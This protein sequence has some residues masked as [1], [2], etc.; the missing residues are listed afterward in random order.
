MSEMFTW[1]G[2]SLLEHWTIWFVTLVLIVAAVIDGMLLK[3]PNWLTFPFV[4]S[5]W[6]YST[7]AYGWEG[8]YW[9]LGG[10]VVG[11]IV[12]LIPYC[13]G[14][15][16][17]GDVK[18]MAGVGAW[19]Y[20]THTL[21]GFFATTIVGAVLAIAMVIWSGQFKKHY[22]QFWLIA[23]EIFMIRDPEKLSEIAAQRKPSM[24]LLPYGI[25]MAIGIIGYF[26]GSG[27]LK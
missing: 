3:V 16:G 15:M 19:V 18:L 2:S 24:K 1:L 11:L 12:L 8:L 23:N 21:Y 27:L 10:T 6:I 13:I 14:G 7:A 25:P 17:A 4:I 9:S 22:A 26:V 20:G 5:G